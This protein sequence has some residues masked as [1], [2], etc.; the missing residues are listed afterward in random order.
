MSDPLGA[1]LSRPID[2]GEA[3]ILVRT[4]GAGPP[5][6]LLHGHP[7]T[8]LA[9]RLVAPRLA[10]HFT[11]VLMDLRGYGDSSKPDPAPDHSTY[12]KRAM[13]RDGVAVMRQLGFEDWFVAGHDRGGYVAYRMALDHPEHVRRLAVLDIVPAAEAWNRADAA[14]MLAWW[15]WAF[16]AQPAPLPEHLVGLDPDWFLTRSPRRVAAWGDALEEYRRCYRDPA[17]RRAMFEDY[18][19]NAS[20]DR[21]HDEATLAAGDRIRC[22]VLALWAGQDDLAALHGDPLAIWR[23]WAEDLRGHA[24]DAGHDLPE[25]APA[26]VASALT[27]FF[28]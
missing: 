25:E 22:P 23:H 1:F 10:H 8:H 24:I 3:R 21:E 26:E 17:T 2:T 15:H 9:W 5:V 13:A 28:S 16:F 20:I 27:S 11:V 4:G 14:F 19:A 6:L 18:R 7:Q 12:S